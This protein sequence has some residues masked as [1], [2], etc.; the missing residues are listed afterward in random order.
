MKKLIN[1][2]SLVA[3]LVA[4]TS[5]GDNLTNATYTIQD[6]DGDVHAIRCYENGKVLITKI[7]GRNVDIQD[8][9]VLYICFGEGNKTEIRD[10]QRDGKTIK[11]AEGGVIKD[12][13][14]FEDNT[15]KWQGVEFKPDARFSTI[16][17]CGKY[18]GTAYVTNDGDEKI[19]LV[20]VDESKVFQVSRKRKV[21]C[22]YEIEDDKLYI[23]NLN[24]ILEEGKDKLIYNQS[25]QSLI[26][27]KTDMKLDDLKFHEEFGNRRMEKTF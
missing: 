19:Y 11:L 27:K 3:V 2:F 4:F 7:E 26:F 8:H 22:N 10:F 15:I 5:C 12:A 25:Y 1:V 9:K 21:L 23:D 16:K 14:I 20:F 24:I 18:G 6:K 17:K 13:F